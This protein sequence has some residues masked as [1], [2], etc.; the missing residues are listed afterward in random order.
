AVLLVAGVEEGADMTGTVENRPCQM[1][2]TLICRRDHG[3][4]CLGALRNAGWLWGCKFRAAEGCLPRRG[5]RLAPLLL[6]LAHQFRGLH[7]E[8]LGELEESGERRHVA[9]ALHHAE[10][11]VVH[12]AT[13]REF[14][15]R[16]AARQ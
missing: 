3:A 15:E 16:P 6:D 2:R 1:N 13:R 5:T 11:G 7:A 9:A 10:V 12:A 14:H 4:S 8:D